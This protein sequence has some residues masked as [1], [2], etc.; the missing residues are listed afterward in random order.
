MMTSTDMMPDKYER[1]LTVIAQRARA[2]HGDDD[3][4]AFAYF[5]AHVES[6]VDIDTVFADL[7]TNI[8][9]LLKH[10]GTRH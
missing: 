1:L 7:I 5:R 9:E 3:A 2:V 4:K 8:G 10:D 6:L